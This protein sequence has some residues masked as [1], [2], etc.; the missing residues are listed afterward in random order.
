MGWDICAIGKHKLDTRDIETLAK[1]ISIEYGYDR[2]WELSEKDCTVKNSKDY[3]W[4][5]LRWKQNS[6]S[7]ARVVGNLSRYVRPAVLTTDLKK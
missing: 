7:S 2:F 1:D 4:V 6:K 3:E 5:S